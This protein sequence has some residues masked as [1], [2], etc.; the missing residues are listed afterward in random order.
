VE[1]SGGD[2]AELAVERATFLSS[3]VARTAIHVP[4][5]KFVSEQT[6]VRA[7]V[8]IVTCNHALCEMHPNALVRNSNLLL[9]GPGCRAFV[10]EGWGSTVRRPIWT[11]GKA[12]SEAGF[13]FAN[14]DIHASIAVRADSSA[15]EHAMRLPLVVSRVFRSAPGESTYGPAA[16]R[17]VAR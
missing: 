2:L 3:P 10:F 15:A 16:A 8:D 9:A 13:V 14:S 7:R 17:V 6:D 5:W 4:W 11:T 12:F 1:V